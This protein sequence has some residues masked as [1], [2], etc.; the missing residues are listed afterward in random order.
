MN[1]LYLTTESVARPEWR[2]ADF[3]VH[4]VYPRFLIAIREDHSHTLGDCIVNA[5]VIIDTETGVVRVAGM[6]PVPPQP[7]CGPRYKAFF[8][9]PRFSPDGRYLSIRTWYVCAACGSG[10]AV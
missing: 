8:D 2:Y 1:I 4:P 6:K 7:G 9:S 10:S 5:P 3:T